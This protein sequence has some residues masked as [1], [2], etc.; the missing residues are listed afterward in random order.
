MRARVLPG[1]AHSQGQCLRA[2][3]ARLAAR[4]HARNGDV[5][6]HGKRAVPLDRRELFAAARE[7]R[8]KPSALTVT[9]SNSSR[10]REPHPAP[11]D[12]QC[13]GARGDCAVSAAI[14][15]CRLHTGDPDSVAS[16]ARR[17]CW[18]CRAEHHRCA[19]S[20]A[21]RPGPVAGLRLRRRAHAPAALR[22]AV[23]A[24]VSLIGH[25]LYEHRNIELFLHLM[26]SFQKRSFI[27]VRTR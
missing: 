13:I 22:N 2:V 4:S 19:R 27:I 24:A 17:H 7:Q 10:S 1:A 21:R 12:H 18:S 23:G 8:A 15:S 6:Q 25:S 26:L 16:A 9:E 11:D 20:C 3:Y 5:A 14:E